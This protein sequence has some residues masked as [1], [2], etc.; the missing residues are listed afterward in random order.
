MCTN[1]LNYLFIKFNYRE[2]KGNFDVIF[3]AFHFI[4]RYFRTDFLKQISYIEYKLNRVS[5]Q[6]RSCALKLIAYLS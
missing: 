6:Y 4:S 1:S 2:R 5:K 3:N